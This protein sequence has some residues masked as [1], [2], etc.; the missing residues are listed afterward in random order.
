LPPNGSI[1]I[2]I[3]LITLRVILAVQ[4]P[5]VFDVTSHGV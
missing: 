5:L 1:D 3:V 2:F 4:K